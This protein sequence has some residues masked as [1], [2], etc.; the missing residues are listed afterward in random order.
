MVCAAQA[1]EAHLL[2]V[3]LRCRQACVSVLPMTRELAGCAVSLG[4]G[5]LPGA[6]RGSTVP[7]ISVASPARKIA[8]SMS[9]ST[10]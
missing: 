8:W 1:P 4:N 10:E 7:A 5:K 6:E 3:H 2:L 9:R